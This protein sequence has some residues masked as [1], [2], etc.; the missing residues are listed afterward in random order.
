M[1]S[2]R[3][4]PGSA[5]LLGSWLLIVVALI[6]CGPPTDQ[7]SIQISG[8]TMGTYYVV[9][10]A[11][12]PAGLTAHELKQAVE[13]ILDRVIAEISTY[14]PESELSR[15][16]QNR[17]TD[18]VP[19]SANL[20]E[21]VAESL[22][23]SRLTDGTYDPTIGPLVNLWGFGAQGRVAE[24]PT[25]AAV[26][27]AA[28]R[29]GFDQLAWRAE[30]PALRKARPDLYLDLSSL[31]EGYGADLIADF[32]E[33]RGL[34][35]YLVAVA[36]TL[37]VK[38]LNTRG[39][40]W[41]IAIEEPTPGYRAVHRIIQIGDG[42]LSTSGDYRNYFEHEDRR[43][44]HQIDPRTG[45]PVFHRVASVT[46][47]GES[48]TSVDGLATALMVLGDERG[49][50]LAEAEGIAAYFILRGDDDDFES[51]ATPAFEALFD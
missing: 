26:A 15:F 49:P 9:Q 48:A 40:P 18:W 45:E 39:T 37:R 12:P 8:P 38:G 50:A 24:P 10:V 46:V 17:S 16:N 28:E 4:R 22:E 23:L 11:D 29:V 33:S 20:V 7:E 14:E 47:V 3:R 1:T 27:A 44:S 13:T 25:A 6:G 21:I 2:T 35:H 5:A 43:Y 19:V 51:W 36:G 31:G 32:L 41:A 42:A 30:P 34:D